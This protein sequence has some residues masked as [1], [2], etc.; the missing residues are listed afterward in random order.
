MSYWTDICDY[1]LSFALK[2][3]LNFVHF[4][5]QLVPIFTNISSITLYYEI[6][7]FRLI[8]FC[9]WRRFLLKKNGVQ[10]CLS[11]SFKYT[12]YLDF[13]IFYCIKYK[14]FGRKIWK[15]TRSSPQNKQFVWKLTTVDLLY[16][17]LQMLNGTIIIVTIFLFESRK[18]TSNL[19]QDSY[20]NLPNSC[21]NVCAI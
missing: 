15:L 4:Y 17:Q 1:W 14:W 18:I 20:I 21:M 9:K 8:F 16:E 7:Q 11:E 6:P 19:K 3:T 12:M 13:N 2:W 10:A 5:S